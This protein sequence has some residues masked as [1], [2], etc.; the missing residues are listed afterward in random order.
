MPDHRSPSVPVRR[1]AR[2]WSRSARWTLA[3]L[4][5]VAAVPLAPAPAVATTDQA[6]AESR[7]AAARW[8]TQRQQESGSLGA[9]RGLDAAWA[10]LGL[11]GNRMHAAD[12]RAAGNPLLPSAQDYYA[13]LWAGPDDTVWS[14]SGAPQATDYART[15]LV[16]IASGIDPTRIAPQQHL[17]AKLAGQWRDGYIQ[18]R[19]ALLNQTIFGL[20]ALQRVDA[21][22]P[23]LIERLAGSIEAAQHVNGGYSFVTAETPPTVPGGPSPLASPS[24]DLDFTGAAIAALCGAGR[25]TADPSV[26]DAI[27]F[28]QTKRLASGA[29][30]S[31]IG[32]VDSNAWVLQGLGACGVR[33]GTA[34]WV[35]GGFEST[36]DW[37]VTSQRPDGA[38]PL[39]PEMAGSQPADAYATQD[40][41]RALIDRPGFAVE[42][43]SRTVGGDPVQRPVAPVT[44][45]TPIS[46]A[47]AI[48]AG[49]GE[50]GFCEVPTVEG[51]TLRDLLQS[52]RGSATPVGCVSAPRWET[53]A[54]TV[55]NGRRTATPTGGWRWS[56]DGGVSEVAANETR[57]VSAGDV[58]SLRLVDPSSEVVPPDPDDPDPEPPTPD[59]GPDPDPPVDPPV[60]PPPG[61]PAPSVRSAVPAP[62]STPV[63]RTTVRTSCRRTSRNRA[64]TCTVRAGGRFTVTATLP[65]RKAVRKTASKRVVTVV[66][67]PRALRSTQRVRLRIAVGKRSRTIT[68][69]A[70]GRTTVSRI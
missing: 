38:W 3:L 1:P 8:L 14:S 68:V 20:L 70:N 64:V 67:A 4:A 28:L 12:L 29:F 26:A 57:T 6:V 16:A 51:T 48:D 45:G 65:G 43:P 54:L 66:R 7:S 18:T 27:A 37:L 35:A 53:G 13:G 62:S 58:I 30:G 47:L 50:L 34:A 61:D 63:Q 11:A 36:V 44:H 49:F 10:L 21:V 25:T 15:T 9:S 5:G 24:N 60:F 59:P 32:N 17:I 41:L 19:T 52:A 31:S 2:R 22:P 69:R 33:R 55:L 23:A 56:V 42:A 46:I 40:A 39:Y